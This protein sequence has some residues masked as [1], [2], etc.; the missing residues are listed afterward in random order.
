MDI[1]P[2]HITIWNNSVIVY[3]KVFDFA[4]VFSVK[5]TLFREDIAPLR[6]GPCLNLSLVTPIWGAKGYKS[7]KIFL[8]KTADSSAASVVFSFHYVIRVFNL[9]RLLIAFNKFSFSFCGILLL[10]VSIISSMI[11]INS[12]YLFCIW[13]FAI[14]VAASSYLKSDSELS[15]SFFQFA[16]LLFAAD[17]TSGMQIGIQHI[18]SFFRWHNPLPICR[19]NSGIHI[20]DQPPE[21]SF[22]LVCQFYFLR[23]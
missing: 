7:Y 14:Y 2:Q 18:L 1:V 21:L 8:K 9:L 20:T 19:S 3:Q 10:D 17:Y 6:K 4:S 12:S 5:I 23:L 22:K 13:I 11:L 16:Y 15:A